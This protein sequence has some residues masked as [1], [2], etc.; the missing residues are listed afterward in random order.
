[1]NWAQLPAKLRVYVSVLA[2]CGIAVAVW[3]AWDIF[4]KPPAHNGWLVLALL[5]LFTVPFSL[6]LPSVSSVVGIGDA[7]AMAIA[8]M[9]GVSPCV[10]VT[11]IQTFFISLFGQR[12]RRHTYRIVFN[13]SSTICAA[14]L[15]GNIY[16]V[17]SRGDLK[18]QDIIVPAAVLAFTYFFVNTVLTSFAIAWAEDEKVVKFW[19]NSCMPLAVDY[20][21]SALCATTLVLAKNFYDW[22]DV[23]VAPVI[24]ALW[25]WNKYHQARH[26][27]TEKHLKEQE[28]LYERTVESLA[29]AVD[30]KDQTTYGH[31]RRVKIYA[32]GLARLCG[33]KDNSEEL[34]AIKTGAL[35]HDIGKIAVDDYILNKPGRLSKKEFEKIKIHATAGDEILQQVSF[36][37]PVAKYVRYHHERWDGL[38]YPDGLKGEEIPLG[39]R[40]LSI[41]DAFDA[42]R[43]SRPYKPPIP[44]DE[45][46]RILRDQA[47]AS[48]DPHLV[49]IFI[50]HIEELEQEA[51]KESENAPQLSF[52]KY[53]GE[54]E[55]SLSILAPPAGIPRDIPAE[56][57]QL[58]E[59]SSTLFAYLPFNDIFPLLS[60]R[61]GQLVPFSTCVFF[62]SNGDDRI[63]AAYA[64]G[65]FSEL[66]EGYAMEI[67]KGISGWVAAY[68]YPMFNTEPALEFQGMGADFSSFKDALVVPMINEGECLGTIS[69]Y[70][71][72]SISYSQEHLNIVQTVAGFLAPLIS[73]VNKN[74]NADSNDVTDSTTGLHRISYLSALGPQLIAAAK[75]SNSPVSLIYIEIRNLT[76]II[77]VF[78]SSFANSILKKVAD[79]I[80]LELR[81]TDILVRYGQLGFIALLPGVRDDQ[82]IRC[83]Q[84]LEQRIKA[85]SISSSQGFAID[86]RSGI[87]SCSGEETTVL[88]LLKSA[89]E[90]MRANLLQKSAPADKVVGFPRT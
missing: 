17:L 42:I 45:A 28:S 18:P 3:A 70:A 25:G 11:F 29:L 48:Y 71:L 80:K 58:G 10:I 24:L 81:E 43:F 27:Q 62:L 33:I 4:A 1:M 51:L 90:N 21:I 8:M 56:L 79:C 50:K 30:A 9:Y 84:R 19:A 65:T 82:A 88:S 78:G 31:I 26:L 61:L 59:Y 44:Q 36:P 7:Y 60:Q 20:S 6:F 40:I 85:E 75:K 54:F 55:S 13:T 46:A 72:K 39:A 22:A 14:W 41:A 89:M 38:G 74:R 47:G 5:V 35:L 73:E 66:L 57:I 15:Y 87:S 49:G 68:R 52:R 67:G 77:R 63:T 12:K 83:S 2:V 32:I 69:L 16:R 37:Y 34:K 86:C 64:C 53:S 76:Q 23:A